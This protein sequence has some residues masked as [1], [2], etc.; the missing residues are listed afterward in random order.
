MKDRHPPNAIRLAR[1]G[2]VKAMLAIYAP[3]V[4]DTAISFEIA[5]TSAGGGWRSRTCPANRRP[6]SRKTRASPK[7]S[8]RDLA[9]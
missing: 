5:P 7:P 4:E 2:D 9:S 3:V 6:V 8:A 1:A